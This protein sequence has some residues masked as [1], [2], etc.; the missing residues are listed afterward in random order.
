MAAIWLLMLGGAIVALAMLRTRATSHGAHEA[1]I[2]LRRD[3]AFD[4]A[5]DTIVAAIILDDRKGSWSQAP[6]EG[7]ILV[8]RDLV[9]VELTKEQSRV[10]LNGASLEAI[11]LQLKASGVP[12]G[13]AERILSLLETMRGGGEAISSFNEAVALFP[14]LARA[15][16]GR[17]V[18]SQFSIGA[19]ALFHTQKQRADTA[20]PLAS[21]SQQSDRRSRIA[22]SDLLRIVLTSNQYGKRSSTVRVTGNL[23]R[24]YEIVDFDFHECR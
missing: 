6:S 18:L 13:G 7:D 10:D 17:C 23:S 12:S 5:L 11:G 16:N 4:G 24:P 15:E 14:E 19:G 2:E 20:L 3:V 21:V 8:G 9:H 1:L 22:S